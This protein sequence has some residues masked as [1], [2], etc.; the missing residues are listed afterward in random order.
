MMTLKQALALT[1]LALCMRAGALTAAE[2]SAQRIVS[3]GGSITEIVYAL[4]AGERLVGV[5]TTSLWPEAAQAL[6]QV[7]YQRNLSAEG[8][9][10]LAPTLV[11]AT[12]E[13]GPADVIEQLRQAGVTVVR[14]PD[15]PEP[16]VIANKVRGVASALGLEAA[17][18]RLARRIVAHQQRVTQR[19]AGIEAR[20]RVLF[21]LD[22]GRGSPLA[23]GRDTAAATMIRLAGA[24]NALDGFA[25]YKPISA[26]AIVAAAPEILLMS[27]ATLQQLGGVEGVLEMPGVALTPAGRQRR[28]VTMNGLYLLGFGPRQPQALQ[29]LATLL[30]P[31]LDLAGTAHE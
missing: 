11:L 9:L 26:E 14:L 23:A 30:H 29:D 3:V 6:P 22:I 5:D 15:R 20:P 16:G 19:L 28:I 12:H 2:P 8:V 21:L 4:G 25:S 24:D 31:E 13:A 17:G 7:G 27:D 18:E 1:L 10:S